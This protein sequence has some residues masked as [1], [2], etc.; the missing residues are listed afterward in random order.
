MDESLQR[1]GTWL[2][3][4]LSA[5]QQTRQG[6]EEAL[7]QSEDA[8][9]HVVS[10]FRLAADSAIPVDPQI[11][12]A[13]VINMKNL[14][15][16]RWEPREPPKHLKEPP[17]PALGDS[18]KEVV[19]TNLCGAIAVA[20]QT[21]RSQLGLCLRTIVAA[22]YPARWPA[23][24][25]VIGSGLVSPDTTQLHG[26]LYSLRVLAKVYE[27]ERDEKRVPLHT[28]VETTFPTLLQLADS[29]LAQPPSPQCSELAL[30]VAKVI[31]SSMHLGIPPWLLQPGNLQPWFEGQSVSQSVSTSVSQSVSQSVGQSVSRSVR[32]YVRTRGSSGPAV[33]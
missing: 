33:V 29:L 3:S 31:W 5:D 24:I 11:R 16:R 13:A 19:R 8:A 30:L 26:A 15:A 1:V 9:G 4:T 28:V 17:I 2:Q 22:D 25:G 14:V 23:L 32:T 6:A 10:L 20:P 7:R 18:D 27:F 12:Q 21:I